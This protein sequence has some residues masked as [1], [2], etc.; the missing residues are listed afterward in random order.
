MRA[1]T[2]TCIRQNKFLHKHEHLLAIAFV[3]GTLAKPEPTTLVT[4]HGADVT[5]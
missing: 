3:D 1:E 2:I 5:V 4:K